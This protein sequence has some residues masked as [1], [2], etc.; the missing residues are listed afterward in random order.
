MGQRPSDLHP[1]A[2]FLL[3]VDLG[4]EVQGRP[5]EVVESRPRVTRLDHV[6]RATDGDLAG[7]L[8]HEPEVLGHREPRLELGGR[9]RHLVEQ[10]RGAAAVAHPGD[11]RAHAVPR[12]RLERG[13]HLPRKLLAEPGRDGPVERQADAEQPVVDQHGD[14][15]GESLLE[16]QPDQISARELQ[17]LRR[18]GPHGQQAPSR[19]SPHPADREDRAP[20]L[21]AAEVPTPALDR[22]RLEL[23]EKHV[24]PAGVHE[25][26]RLGIIE[27]QRA[28]GGGPLPPAVGQEFLDEKSGWI[29]FCLEWGERRWQVGRRLG[30]R[31][32]VRPDPEA[33]STPGSATS[34]RFRD[35]ARPADRR[36]GRTW[37][38]T[39]RAYS[40][41]RSAIS[42]SWVPRWTTWPPL[43]TMISSQSRIVVS[44][45]A[46]IKQ[47]QPRRR[48]LSLTTRS[49]FGSSAL[50][51]S[52]RITR[53][54]SRA[55]A[56]AIWSRWRWPPEKFRACSA[57]TAL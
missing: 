21:D 36:P 10:R 57:T 6:G 13:G 1:S 3:L 18:S 22:A 19:S 47:V 52:S 29:T 27:R 42:S 33:P 11:P 38:E 8:C 15:L 14:L 2:A 44:R 4:Q 37:C 24:D 46:M 40:P 35:W 9:E 34:V 45:W 31:R 41:W 32:P 39:S 53:L 25:P 50:E 5:V 48:R 26:D 20:L 16:A 49:V 30:R 51:A 17:Q 43:R 12:T 23:H 54:G 28:V 55:R 7:R 56:R